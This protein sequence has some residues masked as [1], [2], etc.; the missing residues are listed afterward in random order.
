MCRIRPSTEENTAGSNSAVFGKKGD[1]GASMQ[2]DASRDW[3]EWNHARTSSDPGIMS[4]DV[5]LTRVG[6]WQRLGL[7]DCKKRRGLGTPSSSEE[8]IFQVSAERR[9][10]LLEAQKGT[11]KGGVVN[12]RTGRGG[13]GKG[14]KCAVI[15]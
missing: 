9:C 3:F 8:L 15:Y 14:D 1:S 11:S 12:Q 5:S 13:A 2:S 10:P 7:E 6:G 4:E